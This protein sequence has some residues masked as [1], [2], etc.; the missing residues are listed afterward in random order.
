MTTK[1]A[2]ILFALLLGL[3]AS[4]ADARQ[5]AAPETA[6]ST[7]FAA[8]AKSLRQEAESA[9]EEGR[10]SEAVAAYGQLVEH[11]LE[12]GYL[13]A[14][15]SVA[16][17]R[18]RIAVAF[19]NSG[20]YAA[21]QTMLTLLA[22]SAPEHEVAKRQALLEEVRAALRL[23]HSAVGARQAEAS[24]SEQPL[25]VGGDVTR[26]ELV[27]R[28]EAEY[29]REARRSRIQGVVIVEATIDKRG[30]VTDVKVLKPLPMGLDRAAIDAVKKWKF[31][32]ATL[33]G[34]PVVVNY[35]LTVHFRLP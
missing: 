8:V 20:N 19:R 26:P 18:F 30:N 34:R 35:N 22:E 12:G 10:W 24:G 25:R 5:A 9:F 33:E 3:S 2:P 1:T 29:T 28:A 27:S 31:R 13:E 23:K 7:A 21:A 4:A 11:L 17:S 15:Q 6:D 16:G 32:P 14:S